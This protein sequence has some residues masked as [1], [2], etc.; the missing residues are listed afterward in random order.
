M[1][2]HIRLI[3]MQ[4]PSHTNSSA[5]FLRPLAQELTFFRCGKCAEKFIFSGDLGDNGRTVHLEDA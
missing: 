3:H 1:N 5:P 4:V 2:M